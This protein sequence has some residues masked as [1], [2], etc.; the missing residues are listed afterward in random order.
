LRT[1]LAVLTGSFDHNE[2]ELTRAEE[3]VGSHKSLR[4]LAGR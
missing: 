4:A 1:I 2:D 3:A